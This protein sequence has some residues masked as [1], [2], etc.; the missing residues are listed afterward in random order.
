M[1][2]GIL[3]YNPQGYPVTP[4]RLIQ[5]SK[6]ALACRPATKG[7]RLSIALADAR[8]IRAMNRR[9]A[10]I[11]APTDVLSFPADQSPH[12]AEAEDGNLGD[13][14]IAY[15][16]VAGQA[17]A[18]DAGL[19]DLLCLLVIH[20]AL[21]LL[22]YDHATD[23]ARDEMWAAQERALRRMNIDPEIVDRYARRKHD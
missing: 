23:A 19:C 8:T 16:Y 11:D 2:A 1:S 20:G 22:G 12:I 3:V 9:Y 13:I 15:D 6:A 14:V 17:R 21:H 18:A 10:Q 4:V 5:A 7:G